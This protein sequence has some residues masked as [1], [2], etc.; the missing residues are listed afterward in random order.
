VPGRST[1][2]RCPTTW[3]KSASNPK[4]PIFPMALPSYTGK[5]ILF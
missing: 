3:L 4:P 1:R 5:A 2:P